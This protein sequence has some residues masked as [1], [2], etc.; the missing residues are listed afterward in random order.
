MRFSYK[1]IKTKYMNTKN[2]RIDRML[3]F[4][5]LEE[6][7]KEAIRIYRNMYNKIFKNKKTKGKYNSIIF[8][9]GVSQT[10]GQT[11]VK[12]KEKTKGRPKYKIKGKRKKPHLHIAVFGENVSVFC[13]EI[14][15]F[16]NKNNDKEIF[17]KLRKR[18]KNRGKLFLY[19]KE[20]LKGENNGFDYIPYIFNQSDKIL[21]NTDNGDVEF[22]A[23]YDKM[24]LIQEKE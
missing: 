4:N 9:I 13:N 16:L 15:E 12:T 20:K 19:E 3:Y 24:F 18:F 23:M 1:I 5:T 22:K 14:I 8:I 21:S 17:T 6:A 7:E 11:A 10:D 2:Y